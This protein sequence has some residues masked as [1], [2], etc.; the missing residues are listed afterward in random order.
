MVSQCQPRARQQ[1][2]GSHVQPSDGVDDCPCLITIMQ[3]RDDYRLT[4]DGRGANTET[5]N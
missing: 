3:R 1:R 2:G 4:N 5:T